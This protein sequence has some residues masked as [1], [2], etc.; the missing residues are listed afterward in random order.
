MQAG[1]E[2]AD[3]CNGTLQ[4][5]FEGTVK[6]GAAGGEAF[7]GLGNAPARIVAENGGG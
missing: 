2:G 5:A 6:A 7:A 3:A 4:S 1:V